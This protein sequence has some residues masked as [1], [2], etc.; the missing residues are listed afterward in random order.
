MRGQVK[1]YQKK[2]VDKR[3]RRIFYL[4]FY[5]TVLVGLVLSGIS[6]LT[7]IESLTLSEVSVRGNVRMMRDDVERIVNTELA[8][9]YAGM[10][11]RANAFLYSRTDIENALRAVP[12]VENVE[13]SRSGFNTV[14]VN[15]EERSEVANWCNESAL[16]EEPCF[17]LDENGLVFTKAIGSTGTSTRFTYKGTITDGPLGKQVLTPADFKNIQFFI[18][19]LEGLSVDPVEATIASTSDYM[20]IALGGGGKI[21][22]N[23]TDDLSGIL[24]NISAVLKDRSVAPSFSDFLAKLDYIKFDAG[25]KVV[26][27]VRE[28]KSDKTPA[29]R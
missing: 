9:N 10:F 3:R 13:V 15:L 7:H 20:T 21:I 5:S 4:S 29:A 23:T 17:L 25:N 16:G 14:V 28:V 18:H 6:Y 12:I 11:S 24:E 2:L 19:Q 27:K 1:V 22:V 26:Y 8:G